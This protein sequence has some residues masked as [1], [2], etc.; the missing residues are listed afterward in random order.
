MLAIPNPY[1]VIEI[2]VR[3][4]KKQKMGRIVADLWRMAV[5]PIWMI[6]TATAIL[7]NDEKRESTERRTRN[8]KNQLQ[9]SIMTIEPI[10]LCSLTPNYAKCQTA[11]D[12]IVQIDSIPDV[13]C[14]RHDFMDALVIEHVELQRLVSFYSS[15]LL[16][17]L[18]LNC[19][20]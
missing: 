18:C 8:E 9:E 20:S 2:P 3:S 10:V 17:N 6:Q 1:R 13:Q 4:A 15:L 5:A 7:E 19:S 11:V 14:Q 12:N 16:S